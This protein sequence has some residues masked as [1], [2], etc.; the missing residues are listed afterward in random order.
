MANV[1]LGLD[2][3]LYR[4]TGTP[5]SP[6]W[7]LISNVKDLTLTL[8]KGEADA[9]TRAAGGWEQ[10]VA[11]VKRASVEFDMVWDTEDTGFA[12]IRDAFFNNGTIELAVMDGVLPPP[13]GKTSSGLRAVFN[14]TKFTRN[15]P[16]QEVLTVSVTLKPTYGTAPTWYTQTGT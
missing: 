5:S 13:S 16:L 12:A 11:T 1:V 2:A 8:E 7:T 15:E 9:T 4:N 10:M 3:K 6:T 14:V